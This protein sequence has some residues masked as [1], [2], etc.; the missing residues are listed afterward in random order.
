ML[1]EDLCF[2]GFGQNFLVVFF[3]VVQIKGVDVVV[4]ECC[5]MIVGGGEYVVNLV[6]LVFMKNQLGM[7]GVDDFQFG[8]FQRFDFVFQY[9]VVRSKQC[10][11]CF[12]YW[13]VQGDF[14]DFWDFGF[15]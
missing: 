11:F 1:F 14:V 5:D 4:G 8:W 9:Y 12:I 2:V 3:Y 7:G 6:V 10:G 13:L 15:W